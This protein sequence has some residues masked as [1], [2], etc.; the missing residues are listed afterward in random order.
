MS[1]RRT[2]SLRGRRAG[3]LRLLRVSGV[4]RELAL[5]AV[6]AAIYAGVR[7]MTE[8]SATT[9]LTHGDALLRLE[10]RLGLAWEDAV[11]SVTLA[12]D[13][14]VALANWIYIFGHWPVIVISAVI[15]YRSHR[16]SYLLLRNAIFASAAI[17]FAFFA[18]LPVAPPRLLDA[19]LVD[20]VMERSES[21]RALQPP[22][23]TNQ[24]AAF[25][26]LHFGWNLLVGIVLL[27]TFTH[28]AIRVFALVMPVGM[29]LAVVASAN[30]YVLDVVA[31]GVIVLVGLALAVVLA[32]DDVGHAVVDARNRPPPPPG[33]RVA[34][35]GRGGSSD[36]STSRSRGPSLVSRR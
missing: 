33:R 16:A 23:V 8:G 3:G 35:G 30:H 18:F 22:A 26:S 19:G 27:L 28:I 7:A 2:E 10:R 13:T 34:G 4:A 31:G 36:P 21:Y 5:V 11:Q 17:G 9:A 29:A 25:P 20:T 12:S 15:L 32:P 14:L 6:A 1:L 24:Y